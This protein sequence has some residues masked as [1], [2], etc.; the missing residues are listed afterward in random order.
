MEP[1]NKSWK[2]SLQVF[3]LLAQPNAAIKMRPKIQGWP[4]QTNAK[5]KQKT[6]HNAGAA[7]IA[8][9]G[10]A[11][12][13]FALAYTHLHTHTHNLFITSVSCDL[14]PCSAKSSLLSARRPL[15]W[16]Q[17]RKGQAARE[18]VRVSAWKEI[19]PQRCLPLSADFCLINLL[20]LPLH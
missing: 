2:N 12:D 3:F 11:N 18:R 17:S 4:L 15:L 13:N 5:N 8:L 6:K 10:S 7:V 1:C 14:E 9:E 19:T 16:T 20:R